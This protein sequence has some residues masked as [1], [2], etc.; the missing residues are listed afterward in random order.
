MAAIDGGAEHFK[1]RIKSKPRKKK[2][3][4]SFEKSNG[5]ELFQTVGWSKKKKRE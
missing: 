5:F 4:F 2:S 3:S 1:H